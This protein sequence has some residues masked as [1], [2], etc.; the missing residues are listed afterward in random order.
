MRKRGHP[1]RMAAARS[2][3]DPM[4]HEVELLRKRFPSHPGAGSDSRHRWGSSRALL[5]NNGPQFTAEPFK[6][7]SERFGVSKIYAFPCK[8]QLYRRCVHALLKSILRIRLQCSREQWDVALPAAALPSRA[9]PHSATHYSPFLAHNEGG[10]PRGLGGPAWHF[11]GMHVALRVSP[12]EGA[13]G[14]PMP[15]RAGG[16]PAPRLC[17]STF[18]FIFLFF[19]LFSHVA[20]GLSEP[21]PSIPGVYRTAPRRAP[22]PGAQLG[23]PPG[24]SLPI[25]SMFIF[26]YESGARPPEGSSR[27]AAPAS[28]ADAADVPRATRSAGSACPTR[29]ASKAYSPTIFSS[30]P[31]T[32][33]SSRARAF[34]N[35]CTTAATR[36]APPPSADF[37]ATLLSALH[38]QALDLA[39]NLLEGRRIISEDR[40]APLSARSQSSAPTAAANWPPEAPPAHIPSMKTMDAR[41]PPPPAPVLSSAEVSPPVVDFAAPRQSSGDASRC[42]PACATNRRSCASSVPRGAGAALVTHSRPRRPPFAVPPTPVIAS[43]QP[44]HSAVAPP[45]ARASLPA[46]IL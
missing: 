33:Q 13:P 22:A 45:L 19:A 42:S 16:A 36:H 38:P 26:Y 14:G 28:D 20:S 23:R 6:Q 30:C 29:L 43:P 9:T 34:S 10:S 27:R 39:A 11:P 46:Q 21:S 24:L 7:L 18:W 12:K 32:S 35:G 41:L 3:P 25:F 40:W 31:F 2:D 44:P 4:P 8:P 5:S 17:A 37:R 1:A 15:S